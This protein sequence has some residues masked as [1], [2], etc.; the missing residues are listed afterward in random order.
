MCSPNIIGIQDKVTLAHGGGGRLT[1]QIIDMTR[2]ILGPAILEECIL[3]DSAILYFNSDRIAFTTDS[4]VISPLKFPGGDIGKLAVYGTV[5][6]LAVSGARPLYLSL[7]L[8]IEE[9]LDFSELHDILTSIREAVV[10]T[11]VRIVTGDT[12]VV[13]HGKGDK[14]FINTAGIGQ[15]IHPLRPENIEDG[16]VIVISGD[17]GRHGLAVMIARQELNFD[18]EIESD[19]APIHEPVLELI[20]EVEVKCAR[21]LTRGGLA[22]VL[23]ELAQ[24]TN[25]GVE[26][27]EDVPVIPEVRELCEVLGLDPLQ[28]ACEGRFIAI[29]KRGQEDRAL[30]ILKKFPDT[31]NAKVIG[32]FTKRTDKVLLRSPY[33]TYSILDMPSGYL[34]PRIC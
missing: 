5:N 26:I 28:V 33:G 6:D 16:D 21:D 12:K 13:Q 7:S 14:L 25:L 29:V 18:I 27:F 34:L 10:S 2:K 22:S 15:V 17:V 24:T 19:C 30:E 1:Y 3:H 23:N 31:E 11:G 32:S 20:S 4:Y 9:G 8:I